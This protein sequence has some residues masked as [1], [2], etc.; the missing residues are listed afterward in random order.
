MSGYMDKRN[1]GNL[2]PAVDRLATASGDLAQARSRRALTRLRAKWPAWMIGMLA[3]SPV[4][5]R[6]GMSIDVYS[7]NP[8]LHT[9]EIAAGDVI[10]NNGYRLAGGEWSGW[11]APL[12]RHSQR[13]RFLSAK[14][15][16][17]TD[18]PWKKPAPIRCDEAGIWSV[19][20]AYRSEGA[21]D[22]GTLSYRDR[23]NTLHLEHAA[24]L[25]TCESV[26]AAEYVEDETWF[27]LPHPAE[28][29]PF[30][31]NRMARL[32]GNA[33][34]I[35]RPQLDHPHTQ[36]SFMGIRQWRMQGSPRHAGTALT[37]Q[38]PR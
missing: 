17:G 10:F 23:T 7:L 35:G 6:G 36:D 4:T 37:E 3:L 21:D 30:F 32:V 38:A 12:R 29:G 15:K 19:S 16:C 27:A 1:T 5:A 33:R 22:Q 11:H 28:W 20:R 25:P 34:A 24:H 31:G 9:I 2:E 14:S 18:E 13:P 8:Q 26:A